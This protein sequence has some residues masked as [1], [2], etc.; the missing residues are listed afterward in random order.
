MNQEKNIQDEKKSFA[1][2][3]WVWSVPTAIIIYILSPGPIA[4]ILN[5]IINNTNPDTWYV[6]IFNLIFFPHIFIF[7]HRVPILFDILKSYMDFWR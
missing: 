4:Y 7:K 2:S 1:Q 5:N 3:H 6:K